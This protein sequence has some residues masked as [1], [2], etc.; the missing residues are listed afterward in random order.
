M[1][2]TPIR[3]TINHL[4]LCQQGRAAGYQVS[5]ATDPAWLVNMAINRRAGWPDDPSLTRGSALPVGGRYPKKASGDAYNHLRLLAH[6]INT[7]RRIVRW[8]SLGE[9]RKLIMAR[10]PNRIFEEN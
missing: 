5:W 2:P 8:G 10:I 7:P 1:M 9:W 4:R 3:A 6:E